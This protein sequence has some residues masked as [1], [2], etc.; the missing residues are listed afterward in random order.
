MFALF[1]LLLLLLFVNIL[2]VSC[3]FFTSFHDFNSTS[4]SV[5]LHL[6]DNIDKVT[7]FLKSNNNASANDLM[8]TFFNLG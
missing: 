2:C 3:L 6:H 8:I 4:S 5:F 7:D 1:F